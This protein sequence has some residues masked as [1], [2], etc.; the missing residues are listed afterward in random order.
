MYK[1]NNQSSII[2]LSDCACIPCDPEN[3]DWQAYR[4]WLSE[5]N[6]PESADAE[7]PEQLANLERAWRDAELSKADIEVN[8]AADTASATESAW[9][10]YRVALRDWP[11]TAGFPSPDLRP[12][13]PE[14]D[15]A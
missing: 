12:A 8:K 1:L 11:Q 2:R 13:R 9:R 7:T 4:L 10:Q 3:V 14:G 15:A 5:G 6:T